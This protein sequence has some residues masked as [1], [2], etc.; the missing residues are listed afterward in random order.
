MN[1]IEENRKHF[2]SEI[3][4]AED[5]CYA[6]KSINS[7]S[8]SD[9]EINSALNENAL[10]WV[11]ID[12]SLLCTLFIT[13]GRI[14][15]KRTDSFSVYKFL[16]TCICNIDAFSL[17]KL[18]AR[19]NNDVYSFHAV[20]END[21]IALKDQA[22]NW[23]DI[24]DAIYKPI[25]HKIFAHKDNALSLNTYELF[26]K[27]RKEQINNMLAFLS[28]VNLVVQ[29]LYDNGEKYSIEYFVEKYN[30]EER[31]YSDIHS[32]L[33]KIKNSHSIYKT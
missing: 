12:H 5:S 23:G 13:L 1:A 29:Q 20:S 24:F 33:D 10:S 11:I 28:A 15:D 32:L 3:S 27:T 18:K 25:R 14:F 8:S 4:I 9:P 7:L 19:R 17:P 2:A 6:W 30:E 26:N 16:D 21:F 22:R 31:M